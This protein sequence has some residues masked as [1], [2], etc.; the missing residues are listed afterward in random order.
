[1]SC[2]LC[3]LRKSNV[4]LPYAKIG[5]YNSRFGLLFFGDCLIIALNLV[6]FKILWAED[7]WF[8]SIIILLL[9][10]TASYTNDINYINP[11]YDSERYPFWIS[12]L[13]TNIKSYVKGNQAYT[14]NL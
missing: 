6:L 14:C 4:T 1:M 5:A 12:F 3:N 9:Y 7:N 10:P 13:T 11:N 8:S 2:Y